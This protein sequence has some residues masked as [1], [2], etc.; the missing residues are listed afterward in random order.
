VNVKKTFYQWL[1]MAVWKGGKTY[2][3]RRHGGKLRTAAALGVLTVGV[4]GFLAARS[5]E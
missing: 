1:G 3:R 5:S 2:A 4:A